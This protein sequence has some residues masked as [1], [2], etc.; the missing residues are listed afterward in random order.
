MVVKC[1]KAE[2]YIM[3]VSTFFEKQR[4]TV[5]SFYSQNMLTDSVEVRELLV[6]SNALP[7]DLTPIE[8]RQPGT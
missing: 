2:C 6:C 4:S 8:I 5:P 1:R 7:I 3:Q